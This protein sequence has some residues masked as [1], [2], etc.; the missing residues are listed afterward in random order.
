[1]GGGS[2]KN[3]FL[4]DIG[5]FLDLLDVPMYDLEKNNVFATLVSENILSEE[6][7]GTLFLP[8]I[9]GIDGNSEAFFRRHFSNDTV[10]LVDGSYSV[11]MIGPMQYTIH[12]HSNV[13]FDLIRN[14]SA[15]FKGCQSKVCKYYCASH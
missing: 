9:S 3:F 10:R 11:S 13:H 14:M 12:M 7:T 8:D 1:M 2:L 5:D 4:M 6:T 15:T